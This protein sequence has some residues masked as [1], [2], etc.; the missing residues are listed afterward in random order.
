MDVDEDTNV[1][2]SALEAQ[3]SL[4]DLPEE[5][6]E[7]IKLQTSPHFLDSLAITALKPELTLGLFTR[8]EPVFADTC[9][10]WVGTREEGG[11]Q[12]NEVIEAFARIVPFAP[13]LGTFLE[14]YFQNSSKPGHDRWTNLD[15]PQLQRI[16]L[17]TWRFLKVDRRISILDSAKVQGFLG[18]E[19]RG[20]RYLA[21]R[22]FCQLCSAA[23]AKLEAMIEE[24]VGMSE[25]VP[26]DYDGV[27]VDY[28]FLT[29][30]EQRRFKEVAKSRAGKLSPVLD[31]QNVSPLVVHYKSLEN[32]VLLPRPQGPP[33]Q[34]SELIDTLTTFQ[35][36]QCFAKALLSSSPI[37]L[38]GLAGSG[39][40]SLVND[41][42][43]ELGVDSTMVTLHLNE[44]TDAKMLIGMYTSGSIPGSFTWRAGVLTTAVREGRWVFIEDLDRAPN[45]V[46]SVILPL[47]ER[48]ELII[49]SRGET[50]KAGSGFKLL[51]TIRTS[52]SVTGH[53]NPPA[54][55]MLGARLW[56]RVPVQ[57][58]TLK[59]FE[60][61]VKG[62][63]PILVRFLPGIMDV[64]ERLCET[65]QKPAFASRSRTS[66]GRPISSRDLLK[67]C[68]RLEKV[69]VASGFIT[70]NE[71]LDDTVTDQMFM[72]ACD[73]FAGS[74]QTEEARKTV[75]EK[76]AE[77]M[78]I[79]PQRAEHYF[80]AHIPKY[81]ETEKELVIGRVRLPKRLSRVTKSVK[82]QRPF[83]NTTHAKRLLQQV[84]VAV[85]MTEPVLLVGETGIGKTTVVQQLADSLGY[86]L[87]AVNLSQQ[88]EVG[89]LLGGFK[90]VN[91]RTLAVPLKDDFDDLFASTGISATKNQKYLDSLGKCVA[92]GQWSK[93]S[94]LWRE[95]PKMFNKII[96]ELSRKEAANGRPDE[97]P[98][99]RRKT[100]SRLPAL[101]RLKPRW[102]KFSQS[103][104]Q[105]DIQLS[106][107]SKGFAFTFVEGNVVKAARNGDWV[108]LDEI[109]LASPDTLESIADL[110]HDG[111]V[112]SPSILLSEA[113]EIERVQ[114]HPDF[115]IF[116]AMNPATDVGKRDLPMGLR[117]RFTEIYVESPD[118]NLDDLLGVIK[119]Y[120]RG[121]SSNDERAAHDVAKLYLN[122]KKYADEK[123]LVDGANQVP[124]FSLRTLTR[125]LSYVNEITPLYGLRRALYEGFAMGFLTLLDRE[126]E[127]LLVPLINHHLLSSHGNS[128]ALLSQTPKH[129]QD[130]RSYVAFTNEKKN[131]QYWMLQG[132]EP[133]E[134]QVHYIR[135][136]SV[137]RNILNLVRA[138]STRRFPV[139]VQGPTS[140][141]KTSMIEY[142][143]KYSGNKFVRINNHEHTDLQEYLGTYVSGLDGQ[144]RFQEGLLVQALR[145]GH[146]IVLDELNLAP[147]DVL[148]ALNRLLDDNREL[149][150]PETQEVVRPHEN[151]MLFAT[152]NPPG[153]YGGRKTLSRAFRNR[154]LELHF[155]DIPQDELQQI[156]EYRS[157]KVAPSDCKRI[158][159]VYKEL[160]T[161]RQT[162]RLFEQKDSFATLRDLFRWALRDAD[163]REQLAA[164]GYM[165]LAER[166]RN[167]AE[168]TAVK[169][170]IERVMKVKIDPALLYSEGMSPEI[171]AF[172]TTSNSQG[173]VWTGAMRRLYVLV[174]HALRNNEP[175][176]LVGETGCGKTTVC[177]MIADAFGKGLHI[178]NAHQNT[179]TG[180][181]IGAQR[182]VRN[183][184]AI[185]ERLKQDLI[186]LLNGLGHASVEQD[187]LDLLQARFQALSPSELTAAPQELLGRISVNQIK[188]KALFE[189]SDGSL[190]QAM[191]D[192]SFFLLDEISLADDSVLER[193]NSVLE[194][195]RTILLAEKGVEN[196][197]LQAADGFQF[198]AT[199]NPG[200]DYGKR[201]LSPALRNRFTEIWVPSLSEHEDVFQIVEAK[202]QDSFKP[203]AKP[204]VHFAEWF[205]ETYRS[206]ASTS[207]SVRD[208]LAWVKFINSSDATNPY[209]PILHGASMVYIDTLGANP[210]ALLAINPDTIKEER[211]KCLQQL[212]TLLRHDVTSIY[213]Q[214][215]AL[216]NEEESLSVGSFTM[217]KQAGANTDS[218]FAFEAP[219][220][221]L[222]AM[223]VLRA[224]QVQKPILIEGSPGVGK[225]TLVA[226]L[227]RA[228]NRPLTRI[229]LS[230]QTDLMDLFGS[231]I[232]VEGAEA[233]HF[234]WRDAPFL[235]AMQKGEWVLLDEMN[236]ASQSVLEGLNACLDHRGEVYISELDQTFKRHP[237]FCVFAAQNPHHQGGGRK[238][239]PA[240]FVNRFTVV[241][242]DVFR[243]DDLQLICRHNFPNVPASTL[244]SIIAFVSQLE[245][246]IVY[247]R[248]FG[249]QG[250]PWEFNLRDILR[251]L[252]LLSSNAPFLAAANPAD[253][254]NLIFRQRFR[255]P[256]DRQEVGRLFS[257]VFGAEIPFRH[258]FHNTSASAYQVGLAYMPR[259]QLIQRLP[260]PKPDITNRLPEIESVMICIQQNLPSILVGPSGC[261]KTTM[262]EHIATM[263]GKSLVVFP[264][265]ADI[266]TMD[267]V[268]GFEQV[269]PQRAASSFLQE[270]RAFISTR[271]LASLPGEVPQEALAIL[272]LLENENGSSSSLFSTIASH[273]HS[274]KTE[275]S[276]LEF[277]TLA[278]TCS[279]FSQIPMTLENARFE[280]V[281][282]VLVKALE[283]GQWLVLD[284]ANLCSASVLDRLNSLLEPNGS[285]SI[286]EHCGPDGEPKIVKPHPEFRIF[287]TMDSRFGELSRAMRNRAIEIFVEPLPVDLETK[288]VVPKPE[289]AMERYQMLVE[290]LD[291]LQTDFEGAKQIIPVAMDNLSWSDLPLLQRFVTSLGQLSP[292]PQDTQFLQ[293]L[294]QAYLEIYQGSETSSLRDAVRDT[295]AGIL[296]NPKTQIVHPLQNSPLVPLISKSQN[297][298][299]IY[300]LGTVF[301]SLLAISEAIQAQSEQNAGLEVLKP[302]KMNRLQRSL[303]EDRVSAVSKD[304][305]VKVS[306]F[307]SS[308]IT[309][310]RSYLR[311]VRGSQGH[312]RFKKQ[313]VTT[314][315]RFWW[316]T[317]K[318][319]TC[320]SKF[321]EATFQAHL[322]IGTDA[323]ARL[324]LPHPTGDIV[325]LF[326]Q[327]MN[328]D[329]SSGFKLT[330]GLSMEV[331]WK[332]LRP[333][334][335]RDLCTLT[336]LQQLEN[337]GQR[338]DNLRWR[339]SISVSELGNVVMSFMK[340]YRLVLEGGSEVDGESLVN[341]LD[342]ELKKLEESVGMDE[343]AVVPFFG[344]QF[345]SLRQFQ[346]IT[347]M[348]GDG[349]DN[350]T[351][352]S[353][354]VHMVVLA[355]V[356]TPL[357]MKFGTPARSLQIVDYLW[358]ENSNARPVVGDSS[359]DFI[360]SS[361]NVRPIVGDFALDVLL[362]I[363]TIGDVNLQALKLLESE[364]PMFG[365]QLVHSSTTLARNQI[366]DLGQF[367]S[368]FSHCLVTLIAGKHGGDVAEKGETWYKWRFGV[369]SIIPAVVGGS[370]P[371]FL[372]LLAPSEREVLSQICTRP[373]TTLQESSLAWVQFALGVITLYVPDRAFDPDKRQRLEREQHQEHRQDL[374]NKINAL[375]RF[376]LL[377]SG[378][379][380]N[381]R[382][383]LLEDEYTE[384]GEPPKLLQ[385]IYRPEISEIDQ[386][387]GEFNNLLK[388]L[389]QSTSIPDILTKY[390]TSGKSNL[391]QQIRLLQHNVSQI[392]QRLSERFRAYNDIT[393]PVV[394]MLRCL[395]VGLYMATLVPSPSSAGTSEIEGIL[396]LRS[397]TPFLGG[398][399]SPIKDVIDSHRPLDLLTFIATTASIE[400]LSSFTPGSRQ[401]LLKTFH[402]C[403]NQWKKRLETDRTEAESKS[404]LYRFRGSAEDEDEDDQNEFNELFPPY[405]EESGEAREGS[406]PNEDVRNTAVQ[407]AEVH[408]NIFMGEEQASDS[409]MYLIR[410]ISEQLG[411]SY[412]QDFGCQDQKTTRELLPGTLLLLND[413]IEALDPKASVPESYSFYTDTN[414]PEAR[415]LATL[416]HQIQARFRE[417]QAVDEI[418]HMQPLADV[419]S[420]CRELLQFRHT[421]PLAKIITKVEKIHTFMHEWQFGG[422]ASRANSALMQYDNLTQTI[423]SWRRLELSTWAKLFDMETK[424]CEEDAKS[425]WFVAYE[426]IIAAP[427]GVSE[428]PDELRSYAQKLL[429]DLE[430]YFSTAILGQYVQRLQ[431]L[432]QLQKHLELIVLDTPNMVIIHDA[433]A[434]FIAL[435]ARYERPVL[436]YLKRGKVLL[437][438]A[439][440][441]V[442]LLASWKDTNIV[443]LR[444]SAKRSHHKLFKIVRKFRALLGQ[445]MEPI[446]KQGLP[447]DASLDT[448]EIVNGHHQQ[449]SVDQSALAICSASVPN[450]SQ[451][452]KRFINVDNTVSMMQ[453]ASTISES[454]IEG[455][456]YLDSF[457]ANII[458]S[459]AE[460]QKATPSVLTEENKD[461]VKHLKSRK[462]KLFADTLKELRQ[463]GIKYNL[464]V[465]ALAR[466]DSLSLVLVS[467]GFLPDLEVS[468]LEYYF[469]KAVD[470]APRVREAVRQH[471]ED[472]S[473]AE[474]ARSTGF[475]EGVLQTLLAQRHSL[476]STVQSMMKLQV[477]FRMAKGLWG[478]DSYSIRN[479]A[480]SFGN[481]DSVLKWLPNVLSA[482]LELMN[483]HAKLGKSDVPPDRVRYWKDT[484]TSL[485]QQWNGLVELPALVMSS[486]RK[487]I[488]TSIDENAKNLHVELSILSQNR[489][490]LAYILDQ[491]MPWT[492]G[493][494][495]TP[496]N[497]PATQ[498]LS[499]LDSK[500]STICDTILVALEKHKK[501]IAEIP[502]STEDPNWL[503]KNDN[504]LAD[505]IKALHCANVNE[506]IEQAFAVLRSLDLEDNNTGKAASALFAVAQPIIQQ[507]LN[508]LQDAITRYA[509]FHR[510]TCK[511]SYIL[512]KTFI[513]IATQ[514]FCTPSEKSDAQDGK[515][516]KLEGGTGLGDGEGAEDISKDIQ[517]DEDLDEL[518][519]EPN[520]GEK[521]DM[522]DEQ[523]AVDMADGDMEGEMG[524]AEEKGEDDEDDGGNE[525]SGDEMDEE[526][527][528]VD[529]LDP[530]AV[531]EKMWDGDGEQAEK[532]QEGDDSKGKASKDEQVAAQ[533]SNKEADQGEDG[534]EGEEEEEM[535]GAEQGEEVKQEEVEKHDPHAQEGEALDLPEDMELD[536]NEEEGS[537]NGSDDGMGDLSDVEQDGKEE[538]EVANDGKE[539]E[540]GED[541]DAQEDQ[542]P[543]DD[544][545][546]VDLDE[547]P[548]E[549]G[550]HTEEAG[551]KAENELEEQEPENQEGL[552]RDRDDD[553]NADADNAVP[554][555]VQGV[556]EDQDEN[557]NDKSESTSKAQREDGGKG[558]DSSEQKD[559]AAED[560]EKGRQ[561]NGE[562]PQDGQDETETSAD[563]QPFKKLGDVLERWHRQQ[564]KIRDPAEHKEQAK[565]QSADVN[566]DAS[567]F[568]HLQDENAEADEQALGTA[569]EDQAHALDESMAID[570]ESKDIPDQFQPDEVENDDIEHDDVMDLEDAPTPKE[571]EPSEAY[572]GRAG[573]MIKQANQDR[574]EDPEDTRAHIQDDGD[575]DVEEVDNR[576]ES[577]HL[578]SANLNLRS[579]A[580]ARL[581][582]THYESVTRDLSLSLTEQLRLILA[583][584]LATKMRGDFRTGKRLNIKRII[585]YIAS[586][587]KRD[588]IWMRR[589]VPSKRSYQIMLAVDD[590]KSMGESGSGSLAMETLV[591][592]SKSLSMLEVGQICVVGFGD[593]VKVAHEFDAPFSSDAGP[594]VFQNFGFGQGRTDVTKL[595]KDSIDLFRTAR[596]KA[597]G[598]PADLWQMELIISDGVCNSSEHDTIRRLL[599]VA[600]EERIMMVFIIIDNVKEKKKGESVLDLQQAT[601]VDGKLNMSRY[602]DTFPFQYYIVVGDVKE[603]PGVLA[604]LLRQWF[605]EVV[606]SGS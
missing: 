358:G 118:R 367:L 63:Y 535:A 70:G 213:F 226:A 90:P 399:P 103:L 443:A 359:S 149:L 471:S 419:L 393:A 299:D 295:F 282:G 257:Q 174:A 431:L 370:E 596:Q 225:T 201:E 492:E 526:A 352:P 248:R 550:E 76:I 403:Y 467:V 539:E 515:T 470:L 558:G 426:V 271:V 553:A 68:R 289:A 26:G 365:E 557:S 89:D 366:S 227:A 95:A 180:D 133:R 80:G 107:G 319:V 69:L 503:V 483:I 131:R 316:N 97:Q 580:E 368:N 571:P 570:Q 320:T 354:D 222:N 72:E 330:T 164:N 197:F 451:K 12:K 61:I 286:N 545:D 52:L 442:L 163:N 562:A 283:Q 323:L 217:P 579:A 233:G 143:A 396:A 281:D 595:V 507:Y 425:W 168:R 402:E 211:A 300:W 284:N 53:E 242:A 121:N 290:I 458:T 172:N 141:G 551:E 66:L 347:R 55:H 400:S 418:G 593:T 534:D 16:L 85:Q 191:R 190:V 528:D 325:A 519:Q 178:V 228:C 135:T 575:E 606:D 10:R 146:W 576:L 532:D 500:L 280:W 459:T 291:V 405:D 544:M 387:Q 45:E 106:G 276:L 209:F 521:G 363:G 21:V 378:Q 372:D 582:W 175:V 484:F 196:S 4:Q 333:P 293:Q 102:E 275:T 438:K 417:L 594:K 155:D 493:L 162:N 170:I 346:T 508:I 206:S 430:L 243:N 116:G 410:H 15:T 115:R 258:F 342:N 314:L 136:P 311:N 341:V 208:V 552:L 465:D 449:P 220:T 317:Y 105:F 361:S 456:A 360:K 274:L 51:A 597:S 263:S 440:R 153:L 444:D 453:A 397:M 77:T 216:L 307:L 464:G 238:G 237:E 27:Q 253:F 13:W 541:V 339:A 485:A 156:L 523:D 132:A 239:L 219:T 540:G 250:G 241:Y 62:C 236:L 479:A 337:L 331:L 446:L 563:A 322:A 454:A 574:D 145:K 326:Q 287:L 382:C 229:N 159:D 486:D 138:T 549:P 9:A 139:L 261:G 461:T 101:M 518:A 259:D 313:A 321:E 264:L 565:D 5:I 462:R 572:E 328:S 605:A 28:G 303:V 2:V 193:L 120:L 364:L 495:S 166:V 349:K 268:G 124:H 269:D 65:S 292:I 100:E 42:A 480:S 265:N 179:E 332:F 98:M 542:Q 48:G 509:Q 474:I 496:V 497:L 482:A 205:G 46:I 555:D 256:K 538:E 34:K 506:Q 338:F 404:G 204:M 305:T 522:E 369:D 78:H 548:E 564:T 113:G 302:S 513:Q 530:T 117:S 214:P 260:F 127:N 488:Q 546:I 47:I 554:S 424:K 39:K 588:K 125:V 195:Q 14:K 556:G 25:A 36:Q 189:W 19:D 234:A 223:R 578:D 380:S 255:T 569:T 148:E 567:E 203:F 186:I 71:L 67:W 371:P 130:G 590:S 533:E 251:W 353:V 351:E 510:A 215:V 152:Q 416:I 466:Q 602:L 110:L 122:T 31:L 407:I 224:L 88:S 74:L 389:L 126:S 150:I 114:A 450:W 91:V 345:Q 489:P 318:L 423:V 512:A 428:S 335:I 30:F 212:G 35:N 452:A 94:K 109:N 183:R 559:S 376:E 57:M 8:Y 200:G 194:T 182:P 408:A 84:G 50:I 388:I 516:E 355:N 288:L 603:L 491:I 104:D 395:Q 560:G 543:G 270:L 277:G 221:K 273:L 601:F 412:K 478:L 604:T 374:Q 434:N 37:L 520:T 501:A 252:Q 343:D 457:L 304:S 310:L 240:S 134:E 390:F 394:S 514:G 350:G 306:G 171:K 73:C 433:L 266:D 375:R 279:Q 157:Q 83:A 384:L 17:A 504:T 385:E 49:P 527:G 96:S 468:G 144:L 1:P 473:S 409:I 154:F 566:Q 278:N 422:W 577:T 536:G 568:Q 401:T 18:H 202:L 210:A 177:Q 525:E 169:E 298:E 173:V 137:D 329:F 581:Q 308:S 481:Y 140:S 301:E 176:L 537:V 476:T 591:M 99:K 511:T 357:E 415:K 165:L 502:S 460:L 207:I 324:S 41:F 81:E 32:S 161:L 447:D 381:L 56:K 411:S 472:L 33:V 377:F 192:G 129:P 230:E 327:K 312:W 392:V 235:Q 391:L 11:E 246:E 128:R 334:V 356:A 7:I 158:V 64:Y 79:D 448:S 93:A 160:S 87:T 373:R 599:R 600:L 445:P 490:D 29:L 487:D 469:H 427:L 119:A 455:S 244:D 23:D 296:L 420:S 92:K 592:V 272:E 142:L 436:E 437:E 151:F 587:Y 262:I 585:P 198:F 348:S 529:D 108:L 340:A 44:Q 383:R 254:L 435:Y 477:N 463:M 6:L 43:R 20:V 429:K 75:R 22:V 199:M 398:R 524:D 583:P 498:G 59:E 499:Q 547:E 439:M 294:S 247:R 60:E 494:G 111:S 3:S 147:T 589:S 561:A 187:D 584:T 123:R 231:D 598:S 181:L 586:Q 232:P 336:T 573:A 58:P 475:L 379:D 185:L 249:S 245:Q 414:L 315:L 267:L 86:K 184:A 82:K 54:L 40:T 188:A 406:S 421:E 432:K 285:L 531:D 517:D 218:T 112:T 505:S 38:H 441:D 297:Y 309:A 413:K 24:H 167:P 344:N 386:L 362:R